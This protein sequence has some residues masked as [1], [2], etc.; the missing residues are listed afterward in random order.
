VERVP[1]E[2]EP[3][4]HSRAYLSTKKSKLGHLLKMV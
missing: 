4:S 2:V 3:T 1:L